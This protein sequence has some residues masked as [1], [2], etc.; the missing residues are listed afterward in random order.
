MANT[1]TITALP[2]ILFDIFKTNEVILKESNDGVFLTPVK[3]KK[4]CTSK[5]RGMF[6][7]DLNM[8]VNSYLERKQEEKRLDL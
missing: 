7:G 8:T 5:V 3:E 6:A 2:D 4:K 1:V